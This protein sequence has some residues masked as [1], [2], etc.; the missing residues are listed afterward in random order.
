LFSK[1]LQKK[2]EKEEKENDNN[3]TKSRHDLGKQVVPR[4]AYSAFIRAATIA[5]EV[6]QSDGEQRDSLFT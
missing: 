6:V 4:T 2:G 1:E 3:D 5:T